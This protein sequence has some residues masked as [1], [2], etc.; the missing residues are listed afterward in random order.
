MSLEQLSMHANECKCPARTATNAHC[1]PPAI[2][3]PSTY[4]AVDA[5]VDRFAT[6]FSPAT[7]PATPIL[8]T[9]P[10]TPP[11]QRQLVHLST[12]QPRSASSDSDFGSFVSVPPT[13]DPLATLPFSPLSPT[14][15]RLQHSR[16]QSF[17]FFERFAEEAKAAS[18]KNRRGV[19]DELLEHEDDPLYF[20]ANEGSGTAEGHRSFDGVGDRDTSLIGLDTQVVTDHRNADSQKIGDSRERWHPLSANRTQEAPDQQLSSALHSPSLTPQLPSSRLSQ[21]GVP[22]AES[23]TNSDLK[24]KSPG[25]LPSRWMSSLL[26]SHPSTASTSPSQ[27]DDMLLHVDDSVLEETEG[28]KRSGDATSSLH[29]HTAHTWTQPRLIP[30][31]IPTVHA[32]SMPLP[33]ISH[34]NPFAPHTF[35]PP[36]GAP[37]FAGDHNWDKGF[38]ADLQQREKLN[39]QVRLDG[40]KESTSRV[41]MAPLADLVRSTQSRWSFPSLIC[42][43]AP[44]RSALTSRHLLASHELGLFSIA[45]TNMAYLSIP[46]T[47]GVTSRISIPRPPSLAQS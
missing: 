7:P 40:R 43:L 34:G 44:P 38:S 18:E 28:G 19:L 36:S 41:L 29:T 42:Y 13:Q 47:T 37:G 45:S 26:S 22:R 46:S 15:T 16:N 32:H 9:A 35:V 14:P 3:S 11:L 25:A 2:A 39:R 12:H 20:L 21:P 17:D 23:S 31:P 1:T 33:T 24:P 4:A 8:R 30:P 10:A 6:L 27:Y 5:D